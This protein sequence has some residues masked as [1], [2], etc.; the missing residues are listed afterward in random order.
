MESLVEWLMDSD[1]AIRWQVMRDLIGAPEAEVAAERS[2]VA[3]EGWGARLLGL[4]ADDG[5]WGGG[6][7]S[8]KWISTTYTLLLL[9]HLGIDPTHPAMTGATDRVRRQVAMGGKDRPYFT[10]VNEMC[11]ASMVL[12]LGAYFLDDPDDLPQPELLLANQRADGGWNCDVGSDRSS[13]HTTILALEG[14][15][16]YERAVGGASELEYARHRAHEYLL[17]RRLMYSL[18]TGELVNR[19]WLLMSFPPRWFY[20]VLRAL[21][22]FCAAGMDPDPRANEA[23]S[24]VEAK[25]RKDGRW[26]LQNR[27]PGREH[28]EMEEGPG[29]PSR[30][31][32]LRALRVLAWSRGPKSLLWVGNGV[33]GAIPDPQNG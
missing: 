28:F 12:A 4:Q 19:R 33:A 20:D 29:K 7:Y 6:A 24:V 2:R 30:W 14:L 22:Y 9:R 10:Y 25:W 13:F 16:E 1:P 27:H 8:P 31:N 17:D 26:P 21:D 32:T 11:I 18:R 3:E 23:V 15:L 5:R